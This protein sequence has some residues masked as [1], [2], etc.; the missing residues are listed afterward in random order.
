MSQDET[1]EMWTLLEAQEREQAEASGRPDIVKRLRAVGIEEP[2]R[3]LLLEAADEI[4]RLRG[5]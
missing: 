3:S 4:Q 5:F 1:N 2:E